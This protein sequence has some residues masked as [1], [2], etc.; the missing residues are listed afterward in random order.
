MATVSSHTL[1]ATDGSHAAGISVR[2]VNLCTGTELFSA[3]MDEGGRLAQ[4]IDL[5]GAQPADRYELSFATGPYWAALGHENPRVIQEIVLRFAM[6]DPSA[7]YHC[8]IILSPFGYST[9][10]S[11]TE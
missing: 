9:W 4:T 1:N 11:L 8:P 6:P 10:A 5:T 2:L 3:A 7:R